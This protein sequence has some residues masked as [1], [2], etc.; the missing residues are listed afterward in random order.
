MKFQEIKTRW[1]LHKDAACCFE[2][3]QEFYQA[4]NNSGFELWVLL[5]WKQ[6]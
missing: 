5:G 3:I 1:V 2:Q 4:D 6:Y